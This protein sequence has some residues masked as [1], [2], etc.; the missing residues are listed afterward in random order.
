MLV[1]YQY[2]ASSGQSAGTLA[3]G[4]RG[5]VR[6]GVA[7]S[8]TSEEFIK[9]AE[10]LAKSVDAVVVIVGLNGGAYNVSEEVGDRLTHDLIVDF[11]SEGYDRSHMNLPGN[12]DALTDAVTKANKNTIGWYFLYFKDTLISE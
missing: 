9:E 6:F 1:R 12:L 11:E 3:P 5:G 10:D 4:H 2:T 7:P 8:K